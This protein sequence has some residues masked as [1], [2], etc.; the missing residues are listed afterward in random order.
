MTPFPSPSSP[1]DRHLLPLPMSLTTLGTC[2][3]VWVFI[4]VASCV[5]ISLL[6]KVESHSLECTCCFWFSHSPLVCIWFAS[7]FEPLWIC[8]RTTAKEAQRFPLMMSTLH[9]LGGPWAY[10]TL[11][12]NLCQRLE[13]YSAAHQ[14]SKP[15]LIKKKSTNDC[16][17]VAVCPLLYLFC[18]LLR[19]KQTVRNQMLWL[20]RLSLCSPS[21]WFTKSWL[22]VRSVPAAKVVL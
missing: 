21:L 11:H 19:V 9:Y 5:N 15:Q 8:C 2:Y 1:G 17:E 4:C 3:H 16:L 10:H 13:P 14:W 7:S 20:S 18:M 12:F 6:L 22:A